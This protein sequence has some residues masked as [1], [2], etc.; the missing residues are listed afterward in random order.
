MLVSDRRP[1][2]TSQARCKEE[3]RDKRQKKERHDAEFQKGV[4][5]LLKCPLC[6]PLLTP[7]E[8]QKKQKLKIQT[9]TA[10]VSRRACVLCSRSKGAWQLRVAGCE[11]VPALLADEWDFMS[12]LLGWHGAERICSTVTCLLSCSSW[13]PA[14]QRIF[15]SSD[16][17]RSRSITHP[18]RRRDRRCF[19]LHQTSL[20]WLHHWNKR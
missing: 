12:L 4:L 19:V 9:R 20:P 10:C 6:L 2:Q 14:A 17:C 16:A 1:R 3:E 13:V 18:R 7:K 8:N 5:L 15:H 11:H